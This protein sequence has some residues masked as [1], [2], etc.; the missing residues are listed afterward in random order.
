[1][2]KESLKRTELLERIHWLILLRWIAVFGLFV[3]TYTASS[4]FDVVEWVIPLYAIG[5]IMGQANMVFYWYTNALSTKKFVSLQKHAGIQIMSDHF[6]LVCLI[7]F[8]G[9]IVNPFIL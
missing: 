4:I 2:F 6:F 5:I 3:T 7:Y 9:G 1:M 8:A